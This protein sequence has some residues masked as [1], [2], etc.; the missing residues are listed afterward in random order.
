MSKEQIEG[1]RWLA[2]AL[3]GPVLQGAVLGLRGGPREMLVL[4]LGLPVVIGAV[5]LVTTPTLYAGGA[6]FGARLSLAEVL[7]ATL[8]AFHALGL[9]LLGLAPLSLLLG[10]T[11]ERMNGTTLSL[12]VMGLLMVA[13]LIAVHRLSTELRSEQEGAGRLVGDAARPLAGHLLFAAHVVMS[14]IIGA[15]LLMALVRFGEG[16]AS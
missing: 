2:V 6:V 9:A 16:V 4:A 5:S 13:L 10:A 12:Q 11:G 8:R 7:R 3:A 15:R 1:T 14:F